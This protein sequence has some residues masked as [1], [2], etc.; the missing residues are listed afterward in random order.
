MRKGKQSRSP[1][2]ILALKECQKNGDSTLRYCP[3]TTK[4]EPDVLD[5]QHDHLSALPHG[6]SSTKWTP[7]LRTQVGNAL[8]SEMTSHHQLVHKGQIL[9]H[10]DYR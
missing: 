1:K 5:H 7:Y 10:M 4:T 6:A 8:L 3:R 9:C 2:T